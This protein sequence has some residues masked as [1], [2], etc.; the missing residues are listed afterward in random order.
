MVRHP[1]RSEVTTVDV[2]EFYDP[3][4]HT[5]GWGKNA[6][7]YG[8]AHMD[9]SPCGTGTAAKMTLLHHHGRLGLN[10]PFR[11]LSPLESAFD[12][13]IVEE[14]MVG[15]LNAVVVEI[16]GSAYITG[17]HEF[18]LDPRDPFPQGFLI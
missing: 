18:V 16:R 11:N 5:E 7:I 4:G 1:V 14:T 15:N 3:S 6:V 13:R 2:A 10:K 9:R 17:M 12:A 8:E